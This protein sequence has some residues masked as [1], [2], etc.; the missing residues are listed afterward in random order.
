M[1]AV[2]TP[3]GATPRP[4]VGARLLLLGCVVVW[5]WTFVAMKILLKVV[6]PIEVVGLRFGLGLPLLFL[7]A[8]RSGSGFAF[9]PRD[10]GPL[11]VGA[12]LICVHFLVQP[13]GVHLTT[14]TKT[15]WII[16]VTPLVL[17]LLSGWLLRETVTRAHRAGIAMASAGILLLV[18][19]GDLRQL[20]QGSAG[21][22]L[23]L[24]TAFTWALYTIAT[25]DLSRRCPSLVVTCAVFVPVTVMALAWAAV[26]SGPAIFSRFS[27]L[28]WGALAFLAVLGTLAQWFWQIGVAR[29]G[30]AKAGMFLYLEPLATTALAVPLLGE[31]LTPAIVAGGALVLLGVWWGERGPAA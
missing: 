22:W 28:A 26:H 10:A 5:G 19:Q 7:I 16:A 31:P 4:V 23:V 20:W 9:A 3:P 17:A 14:A 29:L 12:A 15:G 24:G 30:A 25:R 21:D 27:P 11:T 2:L 1:T 6:D 8:K 13:I 18:S